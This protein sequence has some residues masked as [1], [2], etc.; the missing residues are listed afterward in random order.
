[1]NLL[2]TDTLMAILADCQAKA[3]D[4]MFG[5]AAARLIPLVR[6]ELRAREVA[7]ASAA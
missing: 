2:S 1:M 5:A 4:P 3:K 6:A 7:V